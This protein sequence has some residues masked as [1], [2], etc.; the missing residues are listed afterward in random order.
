MANLWNENGEPRTLK[1]GDAISY[2]ERCK[3][4]SIYEYDKASI[5]Y[6]DGESHDDKRLTSIVNSTHGLRELAEI[7]AQTHGFS[8][9]SKKHG[10]RTVFVFRE[11]KYNCMYIN[12][13]KL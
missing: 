13:D 3:S 8:L 9:E 11:A 6:W 1:V 5:L 12:S 2:D 10:Y 7:L 4:L